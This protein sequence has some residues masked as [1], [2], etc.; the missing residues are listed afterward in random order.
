M[1]GKGFI[2][3]RALL[4]DLL[5]RF[6]ARPGAVRIL[7]RPDYARFG[8]MA[9]QDAFMAGLAD[10]EASGG[11]SLK[12][13]VVDG[14]RQLLNVRLANVEAAYS[15]LSRT[16]ARLQ[17]RSALSDLQIAEKTSPAVAAILEEVQAAWERK[18]RGFGFS[19]GDVV[20]LQSALTLSSAL[21]DRGDRP[22]AGSVDL[23]TF[24]WNAVGDTKALHRSMRSVVAILARRRPDLAPTDLDPTEILAALGVEALEHPL[25]VSGPMDFD[26]RAMPLVHFFGLPPAVSSR[27][28]PG[29]ALSYVLTV[30][31]Q[32]SFLRHARE[33]NSGF[34][35]LVLFTGGFPSRAV[36]SAI[37]DLARRADAPVFHWGDIDFGGIRI[38][39]HLEKALKTVGVRLR[40]HLMG[41]DLLNAYGQGSQ[42]QGILRLAA[43][44]AVAELLPFV[45]R[46]SALA[47][48]QE[49]MAPVHPLSAVQV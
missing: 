49:G 1:S 44:S 6:E 16:P 37:V 17:A 39:S 40:P 43:D 14:V 25:L 33:I 3:V 41:A 2:D 10:M 15:F 48:E 23:R 18:V 21:I 36:L 8:S 42:P 4:N 11:V 13:G 12:W 24:S 20:G 22:D 32:A 26:G 27:L 38:F 46:P 28:T 5:D 19:P 30:E 34:D 7:A 47:L 31:N 45:R 9:E 29:R 35:G